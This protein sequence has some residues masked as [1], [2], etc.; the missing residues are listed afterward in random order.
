MQLAHLSIM[1]EMDDDI[2]P[3]APLLIE[4]RCQKDGS[5]PTMAGYL[6]C[7][8]KHNETM[9]QFSQF[10]NSDLTQIYLFAFPC[11]YEKKSSRVV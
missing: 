9:E 7:Y 6:A 3:K 11:S 8:R 5:F 1:G 4:N 10:G 2:N